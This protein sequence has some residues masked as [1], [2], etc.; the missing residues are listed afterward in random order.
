MRFLWRAAN[1]HRFFTPTLKHWFA[2]NKAVTSP[3]TTKICLLMLAQLLL[4]GCTDDFYL[5]EKEG[6]A[7]ATVFQTQANAQMYFDNLQNQVLEI[8][9]DNSTGSPQ[10]SSTNLLSIMRTTELGL[11]EGGNNQLSLSRLNTE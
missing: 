11:L 3:P 7:Y 10:L 2:L 5:S 4:S 6:A 8:Q 1:C 9:F